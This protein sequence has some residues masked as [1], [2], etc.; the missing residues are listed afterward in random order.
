MLRLGRLA[1]LESS[2]GGV[3]VKPEFRVTFLED[4]SAADQRQVIGFN[5]VGR[6]SFAPEDDASEAGVT[7]ELF[8]RHHDDRGQPSGAFDETVHSVLPPIRLFKQLLAR[9]ARQELQRWRTS[10]GDVIEETRPDGTRDS[11]AVARINLYHEFT[12]LSE[13]VWLDGVD[14]IWGG[15]FL[16]YLV[17]RAGPQYEFEYSVAHIDHIR[18]AKTAREAGDTTNPFWLFDVG[19]REPEVGDIVCRSRAG[20]GELE[21]TY[22]NVHEHDPALPGGM[23]KSYCAVVVDV[24]PAENRIVVVGGN[25]SDSVGAQEHVLSNGHLRPADFFALIA[26]DTH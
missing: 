3:V 13:P 19:E 26:I 7:H 16:S 15:A 22:D 6:V 2:G 1:L 10:S 24:Q 4:R 20:E 21:L 18:A 14:V 17:K 5:N 11:R 9:L 12:G 8:W 23:R 25:Y